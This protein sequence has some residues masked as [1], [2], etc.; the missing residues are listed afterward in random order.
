MDADRIGALGLSV[1]GEVLL[2]AAAD[3]DGLRAPSCRRGAG[4][5]SWNEYQHIDGPSR[6]LWAPSTINRMIATSIF[7][8]RMPPPGLHDLVPRI[9]A[10]VLFIYAAQPVGGEALTEDY[11]ELA[12]GTKQLW[13]SDSGH[14]GGLDADPELY[15]H[16][17]VGFLDTLLR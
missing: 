3:N 17:V 1:G 4:A 9:E 11:Y 7:A 5:R 15:E 8:N 10:P 13:R 16:H 6:W 12:G 14:T 2:H